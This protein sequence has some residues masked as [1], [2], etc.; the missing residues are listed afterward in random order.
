MLL[1]LLSVAMAVVL[2]LSFQAAQSTTLPIAQNVSHQ[3]T[4]RQVAESAMAMA[5]SHVRSSETW[6]EDFAAGQLPVDT[7]FGSGTFTLTVEDGY[8][9]DGDGVILVPGEG[10]GDLA[11]D[12]T[13][14]A[15]LTVT[16]RQGN[17]THRL[18]AVVH[19][20]SGSPRLKLLYVVGTG[21]PTT[22][23]RQRI[24]LFK[25]W[26]HTV[27]TIAASASRPAFDE[28]VAEQGIEVVYLSAHVN[29][30]V[31]NK[32]RHHTVGVVTEQGQSYGA[33]GLASGAG[34]YSGTSIDIADTSHYITSA[35]A[36]GSLTIATQS[37]QLTLA[38]GTPAAGLSVLGRRPGTA[39]PA[40][41]VLERGGMTHNGGKVPGRRVMLPW[42]GNSS[43]FD[44][45]A[46][47]RKLLRRAL[48]WAGAAAAPTPGLWAEWHAVHHGLSSLSGI[49]WEATP[50]HTSIEP[51]IHWP[52]TGGAL[53]SG[54]P[55]DL[56]GVRLR[57]KITIPADGAWTF[58][59]DSDDGSDL[60]IDGTL[61]VN[62][63]GLHGMQERSGTITLAA[64]QHDLTVRC[65]ENYGGVGLILRWQGPGVARQV[66]PAE[67]F[68]IGLAATD[69]DDAPPTPQL[70]ALY[71]FDTP[72]PVLPT[73]AAH[74]PLDDSGG[75]G[76]V[77]TGGRI[78]MHNTSRIDAYRAAHG[79]YGG[80]NVL[81]SANVTTN[82]TGHGH[83]ELNGDAR[84]AGNLL[85][86]PGANPNSV[87]TLHGNAAITGAMQAQA[88]DAAVS[89]AQS[90]PGG[91]PMAVPANVTY[92]GG[93]RTLSSSFSCARMTLNNGAVVHISGHVVISVI[94]QLTLNDGRFVIPAGSS[95]TLYVG[96]TLTLN[97]KSQINANSAAVDRL[98]IH[99]HGSNRDLTLNDGTIAGRVFGS[100]HLVLNNNSQL[101]GTYVGQGNITLNQGAIHADLSSPALGNLTV[102]ESVAAH[103]GSGHGGLTTG[104]TPP[105]IITDHAIAFDG[106]D[107]HVIV[108]HHADFQL[109]HATVACWVRTANRDKT[110]GV[111]SKDAAGY[112]N[113]GHLTLLIEN[114][115]LRAR[116]QGATSPDHWV[117][118]G[119]IQND[120][121]Y[122]LALVF[123]GGGMKLYINGT[124]ADRDDHAGG[125]ADNAEPWVF[126]ASAVNSSSH[127][128]APLQD[129]LDGMLD[130]VRLYSSAL[131]DE[132]IAALAS[133]QEPG[134]A[135][136]PV[137][138]DTS[139]AGDAL[140]LTIADPA[141]VTWLAGH[142]GLRIDQPTTLSSGSPAT[143]IRQAALDTGQITL[144]ARFTPAHLAQTGPARIVSISPDPFNCN[145]NV[146]Q[147]GAQ[148]LARL[149]TA[150]T[151]SNGTPDLGGAGAMTAAQPQHVILTYN[152][153]Q[154][155]LYRNGGLE[156][157]LD[158]TGDL[159]T[160]HAAYA[161][162]LANEPTGQRPW[163]GTLHRVA[164]WD[165]G[166][167]AVQV[168]NVFTGQ[169]PGDGQSD[170]AFTVRWI[171]PK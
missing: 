156:A 93:S 104:Q 122:H 56:F 115:K 147:E 32:L 157:Q 112:G 137:V 83:V 61:V 117:E 159:D 138:R 130:D 57:G 46:D 4:A 96:N 50:T 42:S 110:Q 94:A 150:A 35:F 141:R 1:V 165:R 69:D 101:Y 152:G 30:S 82:A 17:A 64:G 118:S 8:D 86:G 116:L 76:G 52:S 74:W 128:G 121:W 162:L 44:L 3:T 36:A 49:D 168:A 163:L 58:Y 166:M 60:T 99:M 171:E 114:R 70:V 51:R 125:L 91:L 100:R 98:T 78:E 140:D 24:N 71:T 127:S 146:M 43:D 133:G 164:V 13:H 27:T 11:D 124:L 131:T 111:L 72:T 54:G 65:F 102:T 151:G 10:D 62:N 145:V 29:G 149:R 169:P 88:S 33:M 136:P 161:L 53:Y 158:R 81:A 75:G 135:Y 113:G 25:S 37:V 167:N 14:P 5:I 84:I 154:V 34:D 40:L 129:H 47:G 153:Q 6:R 59:L 80:A 97:N 132:Q 26:G 39:S 28:A 170:L 90:P 21:G 134:P 148:V 155:S 107:A 142:A 68:S 18:Q 66:V 126:G 89:L 106:S 92:N 63:D 77:T 12:P 16:A 95:L 105:A 73:L 38:T 19:P 20:R 22:L 48:E 45:S 15:T 139:G 85:V 79:N 31:A 2:T 41:A 144:E 120:T 119:T 23:E 123:G 7:P 160:W 55:T 67:A 143:K 103:D 87:A 108:P 9:I 109:A